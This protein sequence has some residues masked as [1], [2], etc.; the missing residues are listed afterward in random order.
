LTRRR[1][2]HNDSR[3]ARC[4]GY[5]AILCVIALIST[6]PRAAWAQSSPQPTDAPPTWEVSIGGGAA[7]GP[8]YPGAARYRTEPIFLGSLAYRGLAYLGPAGLGSSE[9]FSPG[10]HY[11]PVIDF[12]GGRNETSD[13][14]LRGL[15]D[16]T[17]TIAAGAIGLWRF[18]GFEL[19]GIVRQ[20]VIHTNYGLLGRVQ[21]DRRIT[22]I[23][24]TLTLLA[25]PEA[26]FGNGRY[27]R[28][29]FGISQ[30]QAAA[31]GLPAYTPVGGVA[32]GGLFVNLD[33]R[34]SEHILVRTFAEFRWFFGAAARS[35][36]VQN[37]TQALFGVGVAYSFDLAD[38]LP[39][40]LLGRVPG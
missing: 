21:F 8:V 35:P 37:N 7:G 25:G 13:K 29:W 39:A 16:I 15:G 23:P 2:L 17:P 19:I 9:I 38:I 28:T 40:S 5:A 36:I 32:D 3:P 4:S 11:G 12:S 14:H 27:E 33:Y 22:L 31:S 20:A 34:Y 26:D 24:G 6:Y 1:D 30:K 10:F 18:E